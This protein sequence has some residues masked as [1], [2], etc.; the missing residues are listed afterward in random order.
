MPCES[1][2]LPYQAPF[3]WEEGGHLPADELV[4]YRLVAVRVHFV[5]VGHLP[6][7]ARAAVVIRHRLFGR[8]ELG[9]VRVEGVA[10][11]VLLAAD[12][13][14][15]GPRVHLEDGV[16]RAVDV[17][18][19]A[20]AEEVLMVVRVDA[21]VDFGAP[22]F[23]VLAGVHGVGVEDPCEFDFELDGPV[24]VEDPIDAVFVVCRGEDVR[25]QEFAAASHNDG[26]VAEVGVFEENT[27]VFFV[28]ADGVFD[29]LAG[30]GPVDEIGAVVSFGVSIALLV[31]ESEE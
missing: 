18:V 3:F 9:L 14:G 28:D 24:L 4:A 5:R 20:H 8:A 30:T 13:A 21:G 17:G 12:V 27:G 19:Y 26:V 31:R 22:A 2:P 23:G 7:P 1:C 25:N 6:R 10:V 11:L 16:E 15:P 29:G